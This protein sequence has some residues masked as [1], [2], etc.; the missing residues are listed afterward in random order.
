MPGERTDS[1]PVRVIE[2]TADELW[3]L[4]ADIVDRVRRHAQQART[5]L[6]ERQPN[7]M[8]P[9]RAWHVAYRLFKIREQLDELERGC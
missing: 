1:Q 7:E 2:V 5:L 4:E 6:Y 3:D 9:P 8:Y